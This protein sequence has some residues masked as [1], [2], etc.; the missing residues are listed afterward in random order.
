MYRAE[1][2]LARASSTNTDYMRQSGTVRQINHPLL[3]FFFSKIALKGTV[4]QVTLHGKMAIP[5]LQRYP[6]KNVED[7]VV[8]QIQRIFNSD[9]SSLAF[10]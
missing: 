2:Q 10:Y 4:S 9:N 6:D 5:D 8:F 3:L 7:T 1:V